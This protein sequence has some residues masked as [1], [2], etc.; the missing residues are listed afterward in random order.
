MKKNKKNR[1]K[2]SKN[3]RRTKE[4]RTERIEEEEKIELNSNRIKTNRRIEIYIN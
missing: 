2:I 3:R 1:T 4:E